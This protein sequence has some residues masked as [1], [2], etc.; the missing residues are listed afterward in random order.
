MFGYKVKILNLTYNEPVKLMMLLTSGPGRTSKKGIEM[1]VRN[2]DQHTNCI[3]A[4]R[5]L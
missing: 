1:Q 3:N 5:R 4:G 2:A